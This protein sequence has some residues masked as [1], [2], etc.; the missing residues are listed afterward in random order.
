MKRVAR[1]ASHSLLKFLVMR[2]VW[3]YQPD[4]LCGTYCTLA[5]MFRRLPI[6]GFLMHSDGAFGSLLG[7]SNVA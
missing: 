7:N 5:L 6:G 1:H 3:L 2:R 4:V